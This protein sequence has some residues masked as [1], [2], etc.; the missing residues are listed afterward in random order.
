MNPRKKLRNSQRMKKQAVP[1]PILT[2]SCATT[3]LN[4]ISYWLSC[5]KLKKHTLKYLNYMGIS[6][7]ILFWWDHRIIILPLICNINQPSKI[8]SR[9]RTSDVSMDKSMCLVD[10]LHFWLDP[11]MSLSKLQLF[12]TYG[13]RKNRSQFRLSRYIWDQMCRMRRLSIANI[14]L[15]A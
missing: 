13:Y 4:Y 6:S 9:G 15:K 3:A 2:K 10:L 11:K 14:W 1:Q 12:F 5:F 7:S 8:W